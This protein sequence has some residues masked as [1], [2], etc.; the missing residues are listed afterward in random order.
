[1]FCL[2]KYTIPRP[3]IAYR[4][5]RCPVDLRRMFAAAL[6]LELRVRFPH[7]KNANLETVADVKIVTEF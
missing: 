3:C 1:M 6:F 4:Q 2:C 5:S 7:K